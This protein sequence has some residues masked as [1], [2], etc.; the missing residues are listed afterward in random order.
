MNLIIAPPSPPFF[1]RE[2]C[3]TGAFTLS[4]IVKPA[5]L[6][7][8]RGG[9]LGRKGFTCN[10]YEAATEIR[11]SGIQGSILFSPHLSLK[12]A[13]YNYAINLAT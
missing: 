3:F 5:L 9:R 6:T 12:Y 13:S 2:P 8:D 11:R 7:M 10:N 1:F 4:L